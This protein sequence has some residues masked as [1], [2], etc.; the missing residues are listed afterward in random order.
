MWRRYLLQSVI[1]D[2]MT[3]GITVHALVRNEGEAMATPPEVQVAMRYM[4]V[5]DSIS[6]MQPSVPTGIG[7]SR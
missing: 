7:G 6:P 3:H 4:V 5:G 1:I 2:D